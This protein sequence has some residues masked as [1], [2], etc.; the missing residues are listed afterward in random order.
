M[1]EKAIYT[2]FTKRASWE[3]LYIGCTVIYL[4]LIRRRARLAKVKVMAAGERAEGAVKNVVIEFSDG[5]EV[6]THYKLCITVSRKANPITYSP[7]E[8]VQTIFEEQI[9]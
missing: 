9:R 4:D 2:T 7:V 1:V 5:K 8:R 3:N 6:V